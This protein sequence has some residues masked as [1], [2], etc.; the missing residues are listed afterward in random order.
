MKKKRSRNNYHHKMHMCKSVHVFYISSNII[1]C[2]SKKIIGWTQ[3][4]YLHC[5]KMK[6][7]TRVTVTVRINVLIRIISLIGLSLGVL[8]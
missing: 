7:I 3:T 2:K 4:F 5:I 8:L 6:I 1:D